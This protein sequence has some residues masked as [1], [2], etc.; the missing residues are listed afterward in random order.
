MIFCE[1]HVH[2]IILSWF[3]FG[4]IPLLF[5]LKRVSLASKK[6][7]VFRLFLIMYLRSYSSI[8]LNFGYLSAV[9]GM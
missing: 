9:Y 5:L 2:A 8:S 6:G 3:V 4:V 1:I 7:C